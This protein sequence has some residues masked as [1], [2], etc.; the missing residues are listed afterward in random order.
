M[1]GTAEL[2][3][4]DVWSTADVFGRLIPNRF[5]VR[6]E[7]H[8]EAFINGNTAKIIGLTYP[9]EAEE[10]PQCAAVIYEWRSMGY[11]TIPIVALPGRTRR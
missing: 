6:P 10:I 1:E 2:F 8:K 7:H 9:K 11:I 3:A 4:D 5:E